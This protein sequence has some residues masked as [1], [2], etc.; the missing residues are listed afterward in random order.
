MSR[1]ALLFPL[2][3]SPASLDGVGPKLTKLLERLNLTKIRDLAWLPPVNLI[4]RPRPANIKAAEN[5]QRVTLKVEV[6][7]HTPAARKGQPY[8]VLTRDDS[9]FL[10]IVL[11][12]AHSDY[13]SKVL[14]VGKYVA[15]SGEIDRYRDRP[16]IVNPDYIL[17]A[18]E[19]DR[20]PLRE[21]VYPLTAGLTNKRLRVMVQEALEH[22]PI[23]PEW[24][25]D[26]FLK[27]QQFIGWNEAIT[28][29]HAPLSTL[30]LLPDSKVRRR[31]AYDELLANQLAIALIRQHQIKQQGVSR[32]GDGKLRE[33]LAAQ[34]PYQLT[35]SQHAAVKDILT[36]LAEPTQML[37]LL[38]GDVGAGKTIVALFAALA[39]IEAGY[40]S[41]L[42]VPTEILARQHF[43]K[44][45][46]LCKDLPIR[47]ALLTGREKGK[48]REQTLQ[49]LSDGSIHLLIGTHALFQDEV[50]FANLGLTIIDEQHRF[51]V[52]QRLQ[53]RR[54]GVGVDML[55]MTA[56]PIPRTLLLTAYGDMAVSKLTEKPPGRTPISTKVLPLLR[57]DEV[58]DGIGRAIAGGAR[59]YWVCPLVAENEDSDL[60]AAETRYTELKTRFGDVVALAH[61]QQ[62]AAER[63][64]SMAA[65][66]AGQ[67]QILV[68]TTVIEVGVDV[69]EASIMVIEHA[70]RFGLA[71]LHQLRGRVG[72]GAAASSCLLLYAEPLGE[73]AKARLTI[74]RETEDG[75]KIAEEDLRLRGAGEV[76]GTRQSGLPEFT[77]ADLAAHNDLLLAARA[78]SQ[79][80]LNKDPELQN[81]RGKAL[82]VLL[83][84]HERNVAA[85]Y[86]KSG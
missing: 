60:A 33:Q 21:A 43:E 14:P 81:E 77:H 25:D 52:H 55:V 18:E 28:Q 54:K 58:V 66:A 46:A 82:R 31:L 34:L 9:G 44:L 22:V 45:S 4:E 78:D 35:G 32:C 39:V 64:A 69:P 83:Y 11:F 2:F 8:R 40:Q 7:S 42:M 71:Q 56:T 3:A 72:R 6:C 59:V 70:E 1:P 13:A 48:A 62:K 84:L 16:Q 5:G 85:S 76:L 15:I 36:D 57:Y 26:A 63:D 12:N 53:M 67:A 10:E 47:V 61:G 74:M 75:F 79:L 51:G 50:E 17:P 49:E 27:Q 24:C 86:L 37:R 73:T 38:Q 29:L 20:I 19:F 30:D 41:A 23:L 68:A 65:F 80:I